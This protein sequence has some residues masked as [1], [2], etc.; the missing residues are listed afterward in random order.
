VEKKFIERLKISKGQ[1]VKSFF[2]LLAVIVHGKMKIDVVEK[3]H[4]IG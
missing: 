4:Q 1:K 3:M 2:A